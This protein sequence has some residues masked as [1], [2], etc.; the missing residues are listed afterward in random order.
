MCDLILFFLRF[1]KI[2]KTSFYTNIS[3][4]LDEYLIGNRLRTTKWH[5]NVKGIRGGWNEGVEWGFLES[6]DTEEC[7]E[8]I[9]EKDDFIPLS[10]KS[11][12]LLIQEAHE[13]VAT[14]W[15][16]FNLNFLVQKTFEGSKLM[17]G[18][19]TRAFKPHL[20]WQLVHRPSLEAL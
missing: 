8:A 20:M 9:E 11:S 12:K 15:T 6:K 17:L 16:T 18:L 3:H 19:R 2:K 5:G 4:V 13:A 14:E 10:R 1:L 7:E